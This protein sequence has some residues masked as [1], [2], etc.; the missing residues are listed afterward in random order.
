MEVRI[1]VRV[2]QTKNGRLPF[3]EWLK[4]V[5]DVTARHS[6]QT[7]I[8]R[9]E[10]TGNTGD[11]KYLKGGVYEMRIH[12]SPGYRIY[13]GLDGKTL[14]V[15]LA[16]GEKGTQKRDIKKAKGYWQDYISSK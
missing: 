8:R 6:I 13:Y 10:V 4:S 11:Y 1:A 15:L 12:K 9:V 2:Y 5:K 7:R 3:I 16:G 14:I